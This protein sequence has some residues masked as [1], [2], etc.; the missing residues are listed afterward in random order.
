MMAYFTRPSE[1][2]SD[3]KFLFQYSKHF[4]TKKK[5]L[6]IYDSDLNVLP[7]G[8]KYLN[9]IIFIWHFSLKFTEMFFFFWKYLWYP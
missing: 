1:V 3:I 5:F 6:S 7:T 4:Y 9:Y 8:E 2:L